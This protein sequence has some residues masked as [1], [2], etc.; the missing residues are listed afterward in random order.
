M[1]KLTQPLKW[2]GGK[3]YLAPFIISHFPPHL[4]YVEPYFG[5][6]SV[7]LARDP[8]RD[9]LIDQEWK[10]KNGEKV[11]AHLR[12]CSE[13]VNDTNSALSN[14]WRVLQHE[15]LFQE[16]ERI[17]Q[18]VPF[19]ASE[20]RG[21]QQEFDHDEPALSAA[22]FFIVARQCMAG[23]LNK[24]CFAPLTRNRTRGGR[25][26][27]ANAW[28][29]CVEGLP[30]IHERLRSVVVLNDHAPKVIKQ[31]DGD[32]TLFYCDPPYLHETR[33]TTAD[34]EHEMTPAQH[35]ELL[36]TLAGVEGKFV[37]SGYD[38]EL[39]RQYESQHGWTRAEVEIDNKASSAKSKEKK[40]EVLWMNF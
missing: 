40:K 30:A 29:G 37:L 33:E 6:G 7:L 3:H 16:F 9:W 35:E 31:Q 25:N 15:G 20:F 26:E 27:Q 12:G 19:S 8:T 17:M 1:T 24:P 2:H 22:N 11:P 23:R 32:K 36:K 21:A 13:V 5:G 39:Y 34:Y 10:L 4:H 14:F 28:L 38:S 18:S